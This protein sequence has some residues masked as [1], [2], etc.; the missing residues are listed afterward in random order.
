MKTLTS[1]LGGV[2]LA[3]GLV[4]TAAAQ[5][6]TKVGFVYVGPIGDGGWTYEHNIGRLA[7]EEHFGDK[8]ETT[9]VESVPEGADAERVLTQM[10]LSG[11]DLRFAVRFSCMGRA[12]HVGEEVPDVEFEQATGDK[13]AGNVAA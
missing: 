12:I 13:R 5:G 2:V 7:V 11:H 1:I 4:G 10:A 6:K 3:L 9:Y 8:V